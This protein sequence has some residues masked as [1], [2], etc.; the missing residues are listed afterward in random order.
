MKTLDDARAQAAEN[1]G[2]DLKGTKGSAL[3]QADFFR[4]E[5][6]MARVILDSTLA[7]SEAVVTWATNKVNGS[8]YGKPPEKQSI[9][10]AIGIFTDEFANQAQEMN[11][12]SEK[13]RG[14]TALAIWG[15]LLFGAFVYFYTLAKRTSPHRSA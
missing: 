5:D 6:E 1:L 2:L 4:L 7:Y 8:F 13:N 11:P 14:K 10:D 12:L 15:L 9:T 3:S